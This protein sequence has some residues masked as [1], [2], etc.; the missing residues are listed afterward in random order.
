MIAVGSLPD[1]LAEASPSFSDDAIAAA[2]LMAFAP[3]SLR[4]IRVRARAGAGRDAYLALLKMLL[5]EVNWHRLPPSISDEHLRGGLDLAA[6]LASGHPVYALGLL[7]RSG[8]VVLPSAERLPSRLAATLCRALD[9][10]PD[11]LIIALDEG[12]DDERMPDGLADRLALHVD[13]DQLEPAACSVPNV[14]ALRDTVATSRAQLT[15]RT[16]GDDEAISQTVASL[17]VALDVRSLRV[18]TACAAAA[19]AIALLDA[20]AAPSDRH[21]AQAVRL[22]LLPR[23]RQLPQ[24][25]DAQEAPAP[26]SAPPEAPSAETPPSQVEQQQ[27]DDLVLAAALAQLPP[28]VL[29][30]LTSDGRN[31]SAAATAAR[32]GKDDVRARHGRPAGT[33][34][35]S[36]THG[37]RLDIVTTLRTA[38]P[39][40]GLRKRLPGGP[41]RLQRSDFRVK[42]LVRP[43][44]VTTIFLVD[45]SG[46]SALHRLAE[47][48]GAVE[49][50]LADCYIRRDHVALIS[51]RGKTAELLLPPTRAL[52]RAKRSLAALPG[53]GGTPLASALITADAVAGDVRRRGNRADIVV[54]TDGRA[55]VDRNGRPGRAAAEADAHL[56]AAALK[57]K[58]VASLVIDT[59][60]RPDPAS[61]RLAAALGATYL[62]LP[63]ADSNTLSTAI[64]SAGAAR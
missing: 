40:Q 49:L 5:Q 30:R 43:T 39:W 13:L 8:V 27:L 19:R 63:Y 60:A 48:K 44:G 26:D 53:G 55:N 62:A 17:S 34:S 61:N 7:A 33:R 38:A 16:P 24:S 37:D 10:D 32:S 64:K 28:D 59:S 14:E 51:F 47:V 1:A 22:V 18:I 54:L 36:L 57:S 50:L 4:G 29:A 15:D 12:I 11:L 31:R 6:T 52:A 25:S 3:R 46:S 41:V 58:G 2:S 45:A 20:R 23:A 56:A 42:R 9:E 35:G 21:M